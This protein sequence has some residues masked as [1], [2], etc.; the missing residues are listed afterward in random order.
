M[1][2]ALIL[3]IAAAAFAPTVMALHDYSLQQ[4]NAFLPRDQYLNLT[5]PE[6]VNTKHVVVQ[7]IE[8]TRVRLVD[9]RLVS[10]EGLK[11][12]MFNDFITRHPG[13]RLRRNITVKTVEE[14]DAWIT[15]GEQLSGIDLVDMNNFYTLEIHGDNP[16]PK[17]LLQE[18]LSDPMVETVYYH[19][20]VQ[21]ATCNADIAPVTPN[22]TGN[23]DYLDPAPDGVDMD[24]AWNFS[25]YGN[26]TPGNW[27]MDIENDWCSNHEDMNTDFGLNIYNWDGSNDDACT[28][29]TA[30]P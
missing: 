11:L 8:D 15:R 26:G 10:L 21:L 23:Q 13:M 3:A 5:D 2:K 9:G 4:K 17:G 25:S 12:D 16:D 7:F 29:T 14:V 27:V 18:L 1:K 20:I 19:P 6:R 24:Y 30:R 22:Y 28:V